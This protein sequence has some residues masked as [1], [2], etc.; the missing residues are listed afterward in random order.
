M[1]DRNGLPRN[2]AWAVPR[3]AADESPYG[4]GIVLAGRVAGSC[5]L[6]TPS[7]PATFGG[8]PVEPP[9]QRNESAANASGL[10]MSGECMPVTR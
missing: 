7:P 2:I 10:K 9:A 4:R 3:V 8:G 5:R 1:S 6:R